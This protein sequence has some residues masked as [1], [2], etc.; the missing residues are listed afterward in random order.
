MF[1]VFVG[2]GI[3]ALLRAWIC[4]GIN[5]YYGT[6][7]VNITGAFFYRRYIRIFPVEIKRFA[8]N[9][10]V[11]NDRTAGRIYNFFDLS[12]RF[13]GIVGTSKKSGGFPVPV[14]FNRTGNRRRFGRNENNDGF[15]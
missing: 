10:I 13:Y 7:I 12:V 4:A 1:G 6:M 9:T 11:F 3:G 5:S 14:F 8:G 15:Y 2:G